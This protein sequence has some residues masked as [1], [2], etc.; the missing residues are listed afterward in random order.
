MDE[1]GGEQAAGIGVRLQ[2]AR[3]GEAGGGGEFLEDLGLGARERSGE[4]LEAFLARGFGDR[5]T[6]FVGEACGERRGKDFLI[7]RGHV[8]SVAKDGAARVALKERDQETGVDE[9]VAAV[10]HARRVEAAE[11]RKVQRRDGERARCV[12]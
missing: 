3:Q 7:G 9:S 6:L 1:P 5:L 4:K 2:V 10:A 11:Q 12:L 8:R